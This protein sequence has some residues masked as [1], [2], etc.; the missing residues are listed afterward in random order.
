[1]NCFRSTLYGFAITICINFTF[2]ISPQL[3]AIEVPL[4][5]ELNRLFPTASH[6]NQEDKGSSIT[7]VY[8]LGALAGYAFHTAEISPVRGFS[9]KPID[10]MI[11]LTPKGLYTGFVVIDHYEP[12]FLK[13]DGPQKLEQYMEQL[14]NV[15]AANSIYIDQSKSKAPQRNGKSTYIDGITSATVTISAMNKT[16][17]NSARA[18]A[19]AKQLAGYPSL[20][21][22]VPKVAEFNA[23][24]L[25]QLV[26][27]GLIKHWPIYK[28]QLDTTNIHSKKFR[29][30][31]QPFSMENMTPLAEIYIAYISHP[32]IAKNILSEEAYRAWIDQ[33]TEDDQY[34]LILGKG[35]WEQKPLSS[36]L[37]LKQRSAKIINKPFKLNIAE[38]IIADKHGK[39]DE[40]SFLRIPRVANFD[41]I[42][43]IKLIFK[44][45]KQ[46]KL[47]DSHQF[48]TEYF[49]T[50]S[51]QVTKDIALWKQ[52]WKQRQSEITI[53]LLGLIV[54]T[55]LFLNQHR[56]VLNPN[57]FNKIR[58][59]YLLFTI[60]F[61][62]YY[63]QGQ[64]SI[65]NLLTLQHLL[66][67]GA[68]L[69][70]FLLDPMISILWCFVLLT[71]VL[72]GRG[73]FCGW[74][75]PFGALQEFSGK[76][77]AMFNVKKW[78]ITTKHHN[79]LQKLKYLLL[80][81]IIGTSFFSLSLGSTLAELEPF[82]TSITLFFVREWQFVIYAVI[83]LLISMKIHKF[84]CRYLC[85]LGA[86]L[87][88]LGAFPI[89]NWLT[90]RAECG[91]PCQNCRTSCEIDAISKQGDI[92]MKECI[93]CLECIVIN[94]SPTLC[95][96][97]VVATKK[98]QRKE[99][100]IN[101]IK[102]INE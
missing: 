75:C 17:T 72:F 25:S 3:I 64:L 56:A 61:I 97:E 98:R 93:Q 76:L 81:I 58:L 5:P 36:R 74:L 1:M 65:V 49:T 63:A 11:G 26:E 99:R 10:I 94:S 39:W 91:S 73:V 59:G 30:A 101:A 8:Q 67:D 52:L 9:G 90:R 85:P 45:K 86:S 7:P 19:R 31:S 102:V 95:A 80:I 48:P 12:I 54:L 77:A 13:G 43:R 4:T 57:R 84:Y 27:S 79:Q 24:T 14:I 21:R 92:N 38:K 2:F 29:Y 18:V 87:A 82:K 53:L 69:T 23:M 42:D 15:S 6:T 62:G 16:I 70:P 83:L 32:L 33:K 41:P 100:S 71:L 68:S 46:V 60:V 35:Q 22:S 96:I 20:S 40:V 78:K 88:L 89:F 55:I 47:L 66:M 44:G 34:L 37:S 51:I 50:Q 28:K